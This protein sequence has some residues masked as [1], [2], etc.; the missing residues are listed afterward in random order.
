[1]GTGGAGSEEFLTDSAAW[2]T[3]FLPDG[4]GFLAAGYDGTVTIWPWIT[5]PSGLS[6]ELVRLG[7]A[8]ARME[9]VEGDKLVPLGLEET[10]K[11]LNASRD[12]NLME[13]IG[14]GY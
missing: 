2:V 13:I 9:V 4:K 12:A 5:I 3:T 8:V 1:V 11:R 10:F 6:P 14:R 7:T